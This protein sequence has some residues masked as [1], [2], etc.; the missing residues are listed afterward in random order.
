[1]A[2]PSPASK[3]SFSIHGVGVSSGI[4]IGHAHLVS[5]A[6]LEVVH[7]QVP[8]ALIAD[9][10]TRFDKAVKTVKHDLETVRRLLP[11]KA[12]PELSAFISTHLMILQDHALS[13]TPKQMIK[14]EGCN[15]EWALKQQMEDLV[16]QFEKFEDEYLRERKQD[17][18]QVVERIIKV[19]L[20]HP[21]QVPLRSQESTIMLLSSPMSAA[22][23]RIRRFWRAAS[24]FPPSLPCNGH[25]P[26]YA[27]A[28]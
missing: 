4:A 14:A 26:W 25:A 28:S 13:E 11:E 10:I 5:H 19:L 24:I 20:G 8:K 16:A 2:A 22:P 6:L 7:F 18:I 23:L 21:S 3:V 1:V 17:V 27:M 9:E 12:P 15:A